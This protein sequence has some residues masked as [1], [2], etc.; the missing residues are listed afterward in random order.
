MGQL[1]WD[2][3]RTDSQVLDRDD[4]VTEDVEEVEEE[5]TVTNEDEDNFEN[6]VTVAPAPAANEVTQPPHQ[7][8]QERDDE[9]QQRVADQN[10]IDPDN[11]GPAPADSNTS[12]NIAADTTSEGESPRANDSNPS[13]QQSDEGA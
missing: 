11:I 1:F 10:S 13:E 4:L 5:E 6:N 7:N 3:V 9:N 12:S 8:V 2:V